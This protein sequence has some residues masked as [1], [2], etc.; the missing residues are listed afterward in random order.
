V[1]IF[2]RYPTENDF[3]QPQ[4]VAALGFLIL[5]AEDIIVCS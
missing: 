2:T 3:P 5:M 4:P 1:A